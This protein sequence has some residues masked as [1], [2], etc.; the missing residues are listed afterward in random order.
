M[1]KLLTLAEVSDRLAIS[2]RRVRQLVAARAVAS[3]RIGR[4]IRV[5]EAALAAY[6]ATA[7]VPATDE[8]APAPLSVVRPVQCHPDTEALE[9]VARRYRL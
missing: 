6:I 9:E 3:V 2:E 8:P 4:L 5:T 7:T 1:T